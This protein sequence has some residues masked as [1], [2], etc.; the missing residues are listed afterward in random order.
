M[1]GIIHYAIKYGDVITAVCSDKPKDVTGKRYTR[2]MSEATCP[3]CKAYL[4]KIKR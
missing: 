4:K 1:T 2:V 3:K